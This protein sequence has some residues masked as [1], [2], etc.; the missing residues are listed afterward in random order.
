M[1]KPRV[2]TTQPKSVW[3]KPLNADWK[4]LFKGLA[5]GI[6]HT[7][8]GKWVELGS[9][10]VESLCAIGI[11]TEPGEL[12]FA[13]IQRSIIKALFDLVGENA[14]QLLI[15]TNLDEDSLIEHL[16]LSSLLV[17]VEIDPKFFDRPSDL[18][19]VRNLEAPLREWLHAHGVGEASAKAITDRMPSYFVYALNEEWRRNTKSY[20]PLLETIDT[21]F[22]RAGEREWAW[23]AYS[24]LLEKRVSEGVFDE[25]FSLAQIF[26]PLNA[27]YIADPSRPANE[28]GHTDRHPRHVV[29]LEEELEKWLQGNDRNDAVR[30]ISGGP[31]SG[32]S[33][34]ARIFAARLAK[35]AK[36]KVLFIPL[37]LID[38][39]RD[40]VEEVGR[41]VKEEGVLF[42]NPLDPDS[43]EAN[44]LLILDGLDELAS[45]GKAAAETARAFVREVERT[46][47]KR[48]GHT[49]KLRVLVSGRELVVQENQSEF[50]RPR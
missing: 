15:E 3:T 8:A 45:Q 40:L 32:K 46:A 11:T 31:G 48:N 44:L 29:S 34:F 33:S 5:K 37:H 24:A 2:T 13:L 41:F 19:L 26:V 9:D 27:Y 50:R 47:E 7:V 36:P 38:A 49:V 28:I 39:G 14:S 43:P 30:V 23:F 4:A 12:A 1:P 17:N 6:G 25:P 18:S 16:D 42:Q 35:A 10:A 21:P 22:T 20:A